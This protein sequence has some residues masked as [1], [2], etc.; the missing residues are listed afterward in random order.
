ME[1]TDDCCWV[2]FLLRGG[3][4]LGGG[5]GGGGGGGEEKKLDC[6]TATLDLSGSGD[7][8]NAIH[9]L[10]KVTAHTLRPINCDDRPGL[11]TPPL[12]SSRGPGLLL[13]AVTIDNI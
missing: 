8:W 2:L 11:V 13:E 5:G 3:W 4:G 12:M 7:R 6:I 9:T 1:A 10:R